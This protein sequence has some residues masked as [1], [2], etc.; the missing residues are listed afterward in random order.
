MNVT[1]V[2]IQ[3][4]GKTSLLRVLAVSIN[5]VWELSLVT[6][7]IDC[8]CADLMFSRVGNSLLSRSSH[9]RYNL[10]KVV[11]GSKYYAA[12]SPRWDSI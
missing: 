3:N 11:P 4:A 12:P 2:G 10:V 6:K 8:I 1:I 5:L 7:G 9:P